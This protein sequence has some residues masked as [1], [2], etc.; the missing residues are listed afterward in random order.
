MNSTL[1]FNQNT[2]APTA[3]VKAGIIAGKTVAVV[4]G[5]VAIFWPDAFER[6]PPGFELAVGS[7]ITSVIT[8]IAA[9]MKKEN[10]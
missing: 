9:Y 7:L 2:A 8:D 6:I 1:T 4:F 5:L 3:K 10:V